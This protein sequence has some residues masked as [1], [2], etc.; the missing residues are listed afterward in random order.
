MT[1]LPVGDYT[2]VV[3]W[4]EGGVSTVDFATEAG[5]ADAI[6]QSPAHRN[7]KGAEIMRGD[8]VVA[9]FVPETRMV[10]VEVQS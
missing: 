4:I 5:A 9:R 2:L 3:S 8:E 7:I 1:A 6:M 10:R